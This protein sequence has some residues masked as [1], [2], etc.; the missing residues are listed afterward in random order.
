MFNYF[1]SKNKLF[2]KDRHESTH[3]LFS[4]GKI[5]LTDDKKK[6]FWKMYVSCV[7]NGEPQYLMERSNSKR[8]RFFLDIDMKE[9]IGLTLKK[10]YNIDKQI[11]GNTSTYVICTRKKCN[12]IKGIHV[13]YHNLIYTHTREALELADKFD[14]FINVDK[15][16]YNT[17]LR[18]VGSLKKDDKLLQENMYM[19][20]CK[21][22]NGRIFR[23]KKE[24][25]Y[26]TMKDTTIRL[27]T[28]NRS[29]DFIKSKKQIMCQPIVESIEEIDIDIT[30]IYH[31]A[32]EF[33]VINTTDKYCENIDTEHK[34]AGVYYVGDV[35][36]KII[37]QKCFCRCSDKTCSTFRGTPI[38]MTNKT[39]KLLLTYNNDIV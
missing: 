8:M 3:L 4:G 24:I 5:Q 28:E 18:I 23:M 12:E 25:T 11:F 37:Y 13:V 27:S 2:T 20:S 26:E 32:D 36:K 14:K 15:S 21:I 9:N 1:C 38:D 39:R 6:S 16:V 33:Y 7:N 31:Q 17:A 22:I 10:F 34:S 29:D 30:G 19:P 35:R